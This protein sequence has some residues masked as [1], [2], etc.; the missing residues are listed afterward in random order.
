MSHG[1]EELELFIR[2]TYV[3][4]SRL[5]VPENVKRDDAIDPH[6]IWSWSL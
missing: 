3:T 5:M 4:F 6:V 2:H 1:S